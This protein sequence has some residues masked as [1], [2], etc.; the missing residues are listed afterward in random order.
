MEVGD[1]VR[2]AIFPHTELHLSGMVGLL[3]EKLDDGVFVEVL[4]SVQ[5][6]QSNGSCIEEE[7]MDDLEVINNY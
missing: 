3:L 5:R 6:V 4:W 1:L 7:Y 2:Y